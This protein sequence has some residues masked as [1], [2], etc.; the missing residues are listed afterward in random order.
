MALT[1]HVKKLAADAV[2]GKE[3]TEW[4]RLHGGKS[5]SQLLSRHSESSD[6]ERAKKLA[7]EA[8]AQSDA[9]RQIRLVSVNRID[10]PLPTPSVGPRRASS[11]ARMEYLWQGSGVAV[12]RDAWERDDGR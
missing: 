3:S 5:A 1:D 7:N 2:A 6:S 4:I 10:A 9:I 12:M 11:S 8:V